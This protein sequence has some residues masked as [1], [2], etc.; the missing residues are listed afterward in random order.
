MFLI[1]GL[2]ALSKICLNLFPLSSSSPL[3]P[4]PSFLTQ[5]HPDLSVALNLMRLTPI[6]SH[7]PKPKPCVLHIAPT[8][9][10]TTFPPLSIRHAGPHLI[11]TCHHHFTWS[12][13]SPPLYYNSYPHWPKPSWLPSYVSFAQSKNST[14]NNFWSSD[15]V[16]DQC[17]LTYSYCSQVQHIEKICGG[18]CKKH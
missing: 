1:L 10:L 17:I 18:Y 16:Y 13:L 15:Q 6:I 5:P 3:F 7:P 8:H 9:I 12:T 14:A 4:H 11:Y 2:S